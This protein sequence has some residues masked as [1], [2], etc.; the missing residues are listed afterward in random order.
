MASLLQAAHKCL[1]GLD[2][3][4]VNITS[5]ETIIAATVPR[6]LFSADQGGKHLEKSMQD[7]VGWTENLAKA[8]LALEQ[9]EVGWA[10]KWVRP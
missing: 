1:F 5:E 9:A 10:L 2:Y 4:E 8:I 3:D 6:A 7:I